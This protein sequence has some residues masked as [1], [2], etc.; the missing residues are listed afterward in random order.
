MDD[1]APGIE[2]LKRQAAAAAA[3]A[4]AGTER[5]GENVAGVS[6]KETVEGQDGFEAAL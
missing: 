4:A 6:N 1:R 2:H 3:A 5:A